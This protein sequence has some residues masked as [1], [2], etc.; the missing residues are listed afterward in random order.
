M[1]PSGPKRRR[2]RH[3]VKGKKEIQKLFLLSKEEDAMLKEKAKNAGLSEGAYLRFLISQKPKD[4]PEMRI[5]IKEMINEVNH[6]GVNINQI[7]KNNNAEFYIPSEKNELFAY[8]NL[9]VRKMQEV[10]A[11]LDDK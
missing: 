1:C 10:I 9:L 3:T 2:V 7:V 11:R 4:Y 5:L 6:I 8:M